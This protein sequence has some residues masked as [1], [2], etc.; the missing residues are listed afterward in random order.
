M[1]KQSKI[2]PQ[3]S[4]SRVINNNAVRNKNVQAYKK[5]FIEKASKQIAD[6]EELE[7]V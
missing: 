1:S 4:S 2:I 5:K 3:S 7:K 6:I